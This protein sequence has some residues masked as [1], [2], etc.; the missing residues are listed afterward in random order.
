MRRVI[1]RGDE[2]YSDD[3][4]WVL[5]DYEVTR[6]QRYPNALTL[7]HI[8]M[9]PGT[10]DPEITTAATSIFS[11]TLSSHLR[12]ADICTGDGRN[13]RILLPTTNEDGG[14]VVCERLLSVFKNRLDTKNGNLL[15]FSLQL[16][17]ASHPGGSVLSTEELLDQVEKA[18]NHSKLKGSNTYAAFSDL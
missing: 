16:G 11:S 7:I 12:A 13:Y 6:S 14:R 4:F 10:S 8:E 9:S 3:V 5:F 17:M 15:A 1:N 2:L 18:L